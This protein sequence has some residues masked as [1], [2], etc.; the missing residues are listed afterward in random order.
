VEG[1]GED[2]GR[3]PSGLM[4]L[5]WGAW[6]VYL[7]FTPSCTMS[8]MGLLAVRFRLPDVSMP[9]GVMRLL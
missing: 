3:M 7:C 8:P 2:A 9:L 5:L 1:A 4:R 6:W